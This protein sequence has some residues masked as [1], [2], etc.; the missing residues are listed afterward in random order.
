LNEFNL[1]ILSIHV[2]GVAHV[3]GAV[4]V[5]TLD[6]HYWIKI[7]RD[8]SFTTICWTTILFRVQYRGW[9]GVGEARGGKLFYSCSFDISSIA[10]VLYRLNSAHFNEFNIKP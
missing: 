4:G 2:P 5:E 1:Y 3:V 6:F 9:S 10:K 8:E 7:G